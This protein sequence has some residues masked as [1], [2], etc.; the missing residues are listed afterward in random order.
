MV[1]WWFIITAL[2]AALGAAAALAHPLSILTAAVASPITTLN[3]AL[4]AGWFAGLAEAYLRKPRVADFES[5]Q[6][7]LESAK[8][9]WTNPIMRTLL[10][11]A[12]ANLGATIGSLIAM[13]VL[14]RLMVGS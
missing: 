11:V 13:P 14:A 3:P 9:F 7:D 10:V 4:A 6:A 8:G 12:F 1:K 2:G 5:L